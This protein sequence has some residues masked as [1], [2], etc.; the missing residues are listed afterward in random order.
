MVKRTFI[1]QK[2]DLQKTLF[3]FP[4]QKKS[5]TLYCSFQCF[6]KLMCFWL[7]ILKIKIM[8][9][10][11]YIITREKTIPWRWP[12]R[13]IV[14]AVINTNSVICRSFLK[15]RKRKPPTTTTITSICHKK[16]ISICSQKST[17]R[18]GFNNNICSCPKLQF[19]C[20]IYTVSTPFF[21]KKSILGHC[22]SVF[23]K[24]SFCE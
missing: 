5:C 22:S 19:P 11:T 3:S 9:Q 12:A 15:K 21:L 24:N 8:H 18:F 16:I 1:Y 4:S 10:K 17:T 20:G 6:K 13:N 23:D 14:P 2:L 7:T